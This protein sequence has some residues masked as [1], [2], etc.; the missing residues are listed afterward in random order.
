VLLG[1]IPFLKF[2]NNL[3][4]KGGGESEKI[5]NAW[6]LAHIVVISILLFLKLD[7][8]FQKTCVSVSTP[9]QPIE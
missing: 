1:L 6:F 8:I 2:L 7:A 9:L 4:R 3:M 5:A